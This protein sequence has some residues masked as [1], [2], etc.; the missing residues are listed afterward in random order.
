MS[1]LSRFRPSQNANSV[2]LF[3]ADNGRDALGVVAALAADKHVP[4]VEIGQTV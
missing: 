3:R 4:L 2:P 1:E